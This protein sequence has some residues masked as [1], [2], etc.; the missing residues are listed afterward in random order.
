MILMPAAI[1]CS[2]AFAGF[3]CLVDRQLRD[4]KGYFGVAVV[5]FGSLVC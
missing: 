1:V 2:V 4:V 3:V 5:L